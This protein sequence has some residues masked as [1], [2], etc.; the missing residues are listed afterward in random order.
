[1]YALHARYNEYDFQL[2]IITTAT[3]RC[4]TQNIIFRWTNN[5]T[6]GGTI[7]TI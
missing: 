5:Y 4:T 7:Q 3:N 1:M 6:K 2:F